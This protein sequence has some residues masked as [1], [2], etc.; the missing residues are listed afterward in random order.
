MTMRTVLVAAA[1]MLGVPAF[2]QDDQ[3]PP[4]DAPAPAKPAANQAE[5][6]KQF[7][8]TLTGATLVGRFTLEAPGGK[9]GGQP[10]E[11]RYH[12]NKVTKMRGDYWLFAARVQYGNKDVTVPMMLQVKWAGDTPVITLTDLAIPG[13]GT[14]TA[15]V[16]I[17]RDH[18]AGYW[19]GGDHSGNLWGRIER[20]AEPPAQPEAAPEAPKA[21][22]APAEPAEPK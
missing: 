11:E 19:S 6:E 1:L 15:R 18:Y 8:K 2:A 5:L 16:M 7:E 9:A 20:N 14:Y 13:L 17:F 12:I 10:K 21:P 4:K 22:D 3:Q